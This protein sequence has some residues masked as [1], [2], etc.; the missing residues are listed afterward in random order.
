MDTICGLAFL[1]CRDGSSL[2]VMSAGEL[3]IPK[4]KRSAVSMKSKHL[5]QP[6]LAMCVK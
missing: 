3:G 5:L 2:N 4:R 6:Q 1:L